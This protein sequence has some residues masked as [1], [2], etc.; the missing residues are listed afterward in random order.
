MSLLWLT[1]CF[2]LAVMQPPFVQPPVLNARVAGRVI[3]RVSGT[4]VTGAVVMLLPDGQPFPPAAISPPQALTDG[5]GNFL[6]ERVWAGRFRI[7][8]RKTGFA[9]VGDRPDAQTLDVRSGQSI[10]GLVLEVA[11]GAVLAGRIFDAG[12]E[13]ASDVV[14]NALLETTGDAAQSPAGSPMKATTVKMTQTNDLGDFRLADLP[15][16]RY[17]VIATPRPDQPFV[18]AARADGTVAVPT[19]YPG[20]ANRQTAHVIEAAAGRTIDGIQFSIAAVPAY[21]VS[22]I[23]V[24]EAGAPQ[25]G[26][27]VTL[28]GDPRPDGMIAPMVA[29]TDETGTFRI[30]R[31]ISGRYRAIAT[32]QGMPPGRADISAGATGAAGVPVPVTGGIVTPIGGIAWS[33]GPNPIPGSVKVTVHDADLSD[34]RLVIPLRRP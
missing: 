19:Y 25:A 22:G 12:G 27:M 17:V 18:Q 6:M 16:G 28:L 4:P 13:P 2:A 24:D 20:S 29:R 33:S 15:E 9:P 26:A 31:V 14:I 23:V 3:D 34:V 5:S 11:R 8:I 32:I 7:R 10:D 21:Q 1:V 30:T